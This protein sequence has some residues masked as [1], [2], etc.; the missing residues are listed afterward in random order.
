MRRMRTALPQRAPIFIGCEGQSEVGYAGWLRDMVRDRNL[1]FHLKLEDLGLGAGD[2]L[3][4][5]ELAINRVK[6]IEKNRIAFRGRYIFLDTDQLAE[7]SAREQR[8]K[9]LAADNAF[10]IIWQDPTH[11]A[12][13]M[14]HFVGKETHLPPTK[15]AADSAL[16]R[17]WPDYRKPCTATQIGRH[18]GLGGAIRVAA[19]LPEFDRLLRSIG[20]IVD[21]AR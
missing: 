5:I 8:A 21:Q 7:D 3:S 1:P 12:F 20:L 18:I 4:R 11:E 10:I 19:N 17:V 14:R 16:S 2:P 15:Q 6:R 9:R 13:L